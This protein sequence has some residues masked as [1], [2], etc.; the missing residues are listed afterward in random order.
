MTFCTRSRGLE[1]SN[2]PFYLEKPTDEFLIL[3]FNRCNRIKF[4]FAIGNKKSRVSELLYVY[5]AESNRDQ[6]LFSFELLS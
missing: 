6:F 1:I 5:N 4:L 2:F 3:D